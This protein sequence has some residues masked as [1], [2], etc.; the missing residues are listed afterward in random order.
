MNSNDGN[1]MTKAVETQ[2]NQARAAMFLVGFG[3]L[4]L[5]SW[6][7]L[8][9]GGGVATSAAIL[10][11][12]AVLGGLC[13]RRW[14]RAAAS[15]DE[16][17]PA[18]G[19]RRRQVF[20]LVNVAQ[21]GGIALLMWWMPRHG[22]GQWMVPVVM[23]MVGLHFLPLGALFAYRAHYV[24]GAVLVLWAMAYPFALNGPLAPAGCL[25][26][27]LILWFSAGYALRP[28]SR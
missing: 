7:R 22:Y 10:I 28:P 21:W 16:V 4:W 23:L 13:W 3:T 15:P 11:V 17:E 9:H 8:L 12:G 2:R 14:R 19:R 1:G 26:A 18:N 20:R 5:L 25:V 6:R 24:T 27:G